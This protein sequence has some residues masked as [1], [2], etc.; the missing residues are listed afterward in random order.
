MNFETRKLHISVPIKIYEYIQEHKLFKEIDG[1]VVELL[2]T[3]YD[4][5]I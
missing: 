3:K 1:I 5:K 4:I 2:I